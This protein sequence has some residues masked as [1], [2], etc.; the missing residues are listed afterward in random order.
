M[1]RCI[2]TLAQCPNFR[3]SNDVEDGNLREVELEEPM[4]N[5]VRR[6]RMTRLSYLKHYL[7]YYLNYLLWL[8]TDAFF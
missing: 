8:V 2:S 5:V 1:C 7:I 4:E 3:Q 6:R